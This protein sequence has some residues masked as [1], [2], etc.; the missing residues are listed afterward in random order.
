MW[1]SPPLST[2]PGTP[3][4][5]IHFLIQQIG[6]TAECLPRQTIYVYICQL[7]RGSFEDLAA[8]RCSG[9]QPFPPVD[10]LV[11]QAWERKSRK[12]GADLTAG[13]R[14]R[15]LRENG[16]AAS[17]RQSTGV[18]PS[19]LKP[20]GR[21]PRARFSAKAERQ[22]TA[23]WMAVSSCLLKLEAF[24]LTSS[25]TR[26]YTSITLSSTCRESRDQ[27]VQNTDRSRLW[28]EI[29]SSRVRPEAL[30]GTAR[31]AVQ[32]FSDHR[33]AAGA[34]VWPTTHQGAPKT[35]RAPWERLQYC[36]CVSFCYVW[37][38]WHHAGVSP[39]DSWSFWP[40]LDLVSEKNTGACDQPGS[41]SLCEAGMTPS[42]HP[43]GGLWGQAHVTVRC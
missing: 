9:R 23:S 7:Q 28:R 40:V 36:M 37:T 39:A 14:A 33:A 20:S 25:Y 6:I 32:L 17:M 41:E 30:P 31:Q 15:V 29:C 43:G 38:L 2:W 10:N 13:W 34:A 35:W 11:G 12:G 24:L 27:Y 5:Y 16:T 1:N 4:V 19:L 22:L 18:S 21:Y 26:S 42:P 8:E 3:E